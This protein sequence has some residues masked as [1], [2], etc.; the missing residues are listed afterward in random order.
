[1]KKVS[2]VLK[3]A[4]SKPYEFD[5][6]TQS[7]FEG[8]LKRNLTQQVSLAQ[9]SNQNYSHSSEIVSDNSISLVPAKARLY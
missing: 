6:H 3:T 5:T 4:R 9:Y 1:M 7:L 8:V 2:K